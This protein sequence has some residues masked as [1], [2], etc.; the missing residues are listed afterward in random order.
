MVAGDSNWT[1]FIHFIKFYVLFMHLN[2]FLINTQVKIFSLG[3]N[4]KLATRHT[5]GK[6]P[7]SSLHGPAEVQG[8]RSHRHHHS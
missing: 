1:S 3:Y 4:F 8:G 2:W 7:V 5:G 6:V